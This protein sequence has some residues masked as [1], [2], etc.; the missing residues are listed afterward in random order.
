MIRNKALDTEVDEF[1]KT[2]DAM[3][4]TGGGLST[5][6]R[7]QL[8]GAFETL[9]QTAHR[10]VQSAPSLPTNPQ[11]GAPLTLVSLTDESRKDAHQN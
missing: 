11:A 9:I 4:Q 8:R 6:S 2:I 10:S 1:L 5:F 7:E 3:I